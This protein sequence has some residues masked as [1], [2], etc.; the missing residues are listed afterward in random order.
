MRMVVM[1]SR[2]Y[3][4]SI[5][6]DR[7]G[8]LDA[9]VPLSLRWPDWYPPSSEDRQRDAQTLSTLAA[10]GHISRE[11]AVKTLAPTYDIEDIP[12]ELGRIATES[13]RREQ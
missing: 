10:A 12:G 11:T 8:P 13:N 6:G 3:T 4:L 7:I 5:A 9:S 1:A 2:K